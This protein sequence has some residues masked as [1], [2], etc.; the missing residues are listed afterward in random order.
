VFVQRKKEKE[1][2]YCFIT[3]WSTLAA[4]SSAVSFA[5]TGTTL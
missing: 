3:S 2:E 5:S 1:K 4:S